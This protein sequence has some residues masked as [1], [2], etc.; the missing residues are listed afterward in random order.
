MTKPIANRLWGSKGALATFA[1]ALAAGLWTPSCGEADKI[2]DCQ[3][4]CSRYQTCFSSG[5]DVDGCRSRCKNNADADMSFQRKADDCEACI[6]DRSCSSA[7]F[8]C[9]ARCAGIVP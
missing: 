1:L 5:Y 7:T 3:S 2:F 4:V 8:N 6:D 9:A